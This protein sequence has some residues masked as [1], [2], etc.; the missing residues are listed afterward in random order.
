MS[1]NQSITLLSVIRLNRAK[2]TFTWFMVL[3]E[4]FLMIL[5]PLFIGFAIDGLLNQNNQPLFLFSL[6]LFVL[7]L[8]GV[9]RRIYDTRVYGDTRVTLAS[10]VERNLRDASVSVR[11]ARLTMSRELVDFIE[12]D[13]PLVIT[14]IIQLVTTVVILSTFHIKLAMCVLI[15]ALGMLLVYWMFH[16]TFTRLNRELNNQKEQ[17]VRVLNNQSL[18][19]IRAHFEALKRCEIKLSDVGA[20]AYGL[21]FIILF[22]AVLTNLWIVST[23]HDLSVGQIFTIVT[24]S[25]E[26]VEAAVMLPVTLQ[27]MSRLTE[28]GQRLNQLK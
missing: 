23:L 8:I 3:V 25:L 15:A 6:I 17:Q 19:A 12:E 14:A 26:F 2:V 7:V 10:M 5:L 13:L 1:F 16:Q 24:Y 21:I 28:I 4:N 18:A 22:A 9:L 20:L 11:D 27:I